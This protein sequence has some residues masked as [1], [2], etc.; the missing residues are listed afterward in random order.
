MLPSDPVFKPDIKTLETERLSIRIDT[1]E[2]YVQL[3]ETRSDTWLKD[4]FGF[5]TDEELNKQKD[6]VFGGLTTYRTSVVFFHLRERS[7][8][9]VIGNFAFHNWLPMH[10]RSE[11]GYAMSGDEYKNLGYMR[12]AIAPIIAFG[13]EAMELNRM[14]A[15]IHPDNIPSKRLVERIGF[16][17]E[18]QLREH[19]V[20]DGIVG[21]SIVYGLLRKEYLNKHE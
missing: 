20:A 3:F 2:E 1:V 13:F 5:R 12:E 4:C 6:K 9:K 16:Q 14:E 10:R 15:F 21:D 8:D 11:I 17:P 18:G 19:Y 7:M